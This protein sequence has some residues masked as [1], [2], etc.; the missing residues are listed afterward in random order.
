L[1]FVRG[2]EGGVEMTVGDPYQDVFFF[3]DP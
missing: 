1:P 3:H 2:A